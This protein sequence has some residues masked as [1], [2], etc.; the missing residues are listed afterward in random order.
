MQSTFYAD[1][2]QKYG[3]AVLTPAEPE[4]DELNAFI[5]K[6]LVIGIHKDSTRK[7]VVEILG[8]YAVDGVILGCTELSL[9]L[10]QE[11]T[12][13]RLLNTLALHAQAALDFAL[14]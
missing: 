11:D 14:S 7:R 6:E 5:F 4:Q 2:F 10:N 13:L 1:V 9:L 8:G 3:L 12:P